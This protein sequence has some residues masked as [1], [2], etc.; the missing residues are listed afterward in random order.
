MAQA[1]HH[2]SLSFSA[3]PFALSLF[4][5]E[6]MNWKLLRGN[7]SPDE[8]AVDEGFTAS[9]YLQACALRRTE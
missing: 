3:F 6:K 7:K 1:P 8:G 5:P 4:F 9:M 2:H